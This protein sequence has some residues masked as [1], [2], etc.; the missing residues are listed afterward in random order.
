M[1][2]FGVNKLI[3]LC[4]QGFRS[5]KLRKCQPK[6]ERH[7]NFAH[8]IRSPEQMQKENSM[9]Q[10]EPTSIFFENIRSLDSSFKSKCSISLV[11]GTVSLHKSLSIIQSLI[12][13]RVRKHQRQIHI[14]I[15][16][17][18]ETFLPFNF[19]VHCHAVSSIFHR[20]KVVDNIHIEV[21]E[22]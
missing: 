13:P 3:W 11:C 22:V 10:G 2:T 18:R 17:S 19:P 1:L 16:K 21:C 14:F 4:Q 6:L 12:F 7:F 20:S 8:K 15:E 9:Q 5:S